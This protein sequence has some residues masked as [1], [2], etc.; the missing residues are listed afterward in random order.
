MMWAASDTLVRWASARAHPL[1]Y[2]GDIAARALVG[3]LFLALV[4]RLVGDFRETGR[5]TDLLLIVGESLVVVLTCFRRNA[6]V[7]DRRLVTRMVTVVAMVSPLLV[8][9]G[10]MDGLISEALGVP[11]AAL[12]LS[13]AVGGKLS[14]GYSF[15]LLPAN[16]GIVQKGLYRMVRHPIYLGYLMT[17]A[18]FLLTHPTPWNVLILLTGDAAL[19]ARASL[20]E[21][22]LVRDQ[23]YADY[24]ERVRW[25]L[26]PGVY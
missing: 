13:I 20:E 11:L 12:G 4:W 22:T 9:P 1:T 6:V 24:R 2:T 8:G 7:V 21:E 5:V 26:V 14:L 18:V 16:R 23:A 3:G 17:H 10:P 25:R 15:G 19:I